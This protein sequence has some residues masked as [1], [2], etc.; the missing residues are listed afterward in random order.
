M[1][2]KLHDLRTLQY[3]ASPFARFT[4]LDKSVSFVQGSKIRVIL[5]VFGFINLGEHTIN[6]VTFDEQGGVVYSNERNHFVRVWNHRILLK[7]LSE[8]ETHY[9]DEVEIHASIFTPF[10]YLWSLAF[11]CHRQRK[12][13]TITQANRFDL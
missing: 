2:E 13:K 5:R 3:I 8:T 4:P 10:V 9:T 6:I 12:W 7:K 1:L 11:Y